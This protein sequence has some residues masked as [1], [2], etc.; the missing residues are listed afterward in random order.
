[1]F[2]RNIAVDLGTTS[3]SVYVEGQGSILS[4]PSLAVMKRKTGEI[5]AVGDAAK[6]TIGRAPDTSWP[7]V[8]SR[9]VS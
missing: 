9:T 8:R 5:V 1:M 2:A 3:T 4:E 7:R 6:S